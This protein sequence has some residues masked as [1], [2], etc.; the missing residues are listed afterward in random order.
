MATGDALQA[1]QTFCGLYSPFKSQL[2]NSSIAEF[3]PLV[4][5]LCSGVYQSSSSSSIYA[6]LAMFVP[7]AGSVGYLVYHKIQ[8][9]C[10]AAPAVPVVPVVGATTASPPNP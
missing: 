6:I 9:K 5:S 2:L 1:I 3:V 10:C 8:D 4:D 7:L